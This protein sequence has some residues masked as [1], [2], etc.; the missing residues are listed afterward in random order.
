MRAN[1]NFSATSLK[2]LHSISIILTLNQF[3]LQTL[4]FTLNTLR[5]GVRYIRT[6]ISA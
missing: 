1:G 5:T 2:L 3:A 4:F 6:L